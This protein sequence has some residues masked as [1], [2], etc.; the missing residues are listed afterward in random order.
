M[1]TAILLAGMLLSSTVLADANAIGYVKTVNGEATITTASK[2]VDRQAAQQ[3]SS[4]G[5]NAA[6]AACGQT[7]HGDDLLVVG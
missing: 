2:Y 3:C 5:K 1:R 4:E 6:R 7:S